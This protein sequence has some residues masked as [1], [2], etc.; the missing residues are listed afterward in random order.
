MRRERERE[1]GR[2][3]LHI[4]GI[5]EAVFSFQVFGTGTNGH[6]HRVALVSLQ[7]LLIVGAGAFV[8]ESFLCTDQVA[9]GSVLAGGRNEAQNH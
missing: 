7:E 4:E 8:Y 3:N 1:S 6:A 9:A 2:I 5:E